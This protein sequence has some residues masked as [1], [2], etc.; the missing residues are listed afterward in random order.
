MGI[1]LKLGGR[2]TFTTRAPFVERTTFATRGSSVGP[3]EEIPCPS[4]KRMMRVPVS[5]LKPG[6][7]HTCSCGQRAEFEGDDIP[8]A[9]EEIQGELARRFERIFR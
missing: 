6:G 1:K 7:S 8:K 5:A 4:C 9:I 2:R 3:H